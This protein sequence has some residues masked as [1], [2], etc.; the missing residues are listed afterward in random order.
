MIKCIIDIDNERRFYWN[1]L[2]PAP[3]PSLTMADGEKD[4]SA[5]ADEDSLL[6]K[7]PVRY[8]YAL[9][10]VDSHRSEILRL[11]ARVLE[12]EDLAYRDSLLGIPNRRRFYE[13][14]A[15]AI[16]EVDNHGGSSAMLFADLNRLKEINDTYGHNAGDEALI[17]VVRLMERIIPE[18]GRI[19][20]LGGDEF[21]ILLK[22]ATE[23]DAC[24]TAA[25]ICAA[26]NASALRLGGSRVPLGISVG[27]AG[28]QPGDEPKMVIDRADIEMYRTKNQLYAGPNIPASDAY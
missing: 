7:K 3:F 20:R 8:P 2:S 25:D 9:D 13:W 19:A 28:I 22:H 26:V 14:L 15:S 10:G 21:G 27:V 6:P 5:R 16:A 17:A 1:E 4:P 24:R 18:G 23:Q 12:L 11:E